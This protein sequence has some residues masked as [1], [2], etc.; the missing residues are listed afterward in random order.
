MKTSIRKLSRHQE[1]LDCVALQKETWGAQTTEI[2]PSFIMIVANKIGGLVAGAFDDE[3]TL[4]GF[5]IGLPGFYRSNQMNWS[6]MLAVKK[7]LQG[8]GIGRRLKLYQREQ[9]LQQGIKHIYWTYDPLVARNAHLNLNKLGAGVSEY[10]ERIFPNERGSDLHGSMEL[11]RFIVEWR[12]EHPQVKDALAG[13]LKVDPAAFAQVDIAN[14]DPDQS[15][16][17]TPVV[18]DLP[19]HPLVRIEIPTD[20]GQVQKESSALAAEWRSNTRHAFTGYLQRG[21]EVRHFYRDGDRC[22]YVLS[23]SQGDQP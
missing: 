7:H 20:I 5:V 1:Y 2:A 8:A 12:L 23:R 17:P 3:N 22:F 15:G 10:A 13:T 16:R 9:L 19:G 21:Y 18:R 14:T 4:I 11:D 6:K